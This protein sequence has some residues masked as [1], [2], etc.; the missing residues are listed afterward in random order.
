MEEV[1]CMSFMFSPYPYDD[2]NAVNRIA[3]ADSLAL[4]ISRDTEETVRILATRAAEAA[5][6]K[7][8]F[9]IGIEPYL[10][11]PA[12]LLS[13][14]LAQALHGMG[15]GVTIRQTDNLFLDSDLLDKKLQPHLPEDRDTDPVL[16][17]GSLFEGGY[18]ALLDEAAVQDLA[19]ELDAF[20]VSGRGIL[21][22]S[23]YAALVPA[24]VDRYDLRLYLDMTQ[25]TTI[26]NMR[27]GPW[28][29]VGRRERQALNLILRRCYYI[30]FEVM[31]ELRKALIDGGKIDY[32]LA[33]DRPDQIQ[34]MT[35]D[36]LKRLFAIMV[37]YPLRCK[38]V[39]LEGVWGGFYL[40]RLRQLPAEMKN[41]A[42]IFDLIP[43]EVSVVA[44]LGTMCVEFPFYSFIQT[45]GV[46]L[47]G[48]KCVDAFGGYF[49]IRFNY[50]DTFHSSGNMSIQV[51]PPEDYTAEHYNELGRQDESYYVV[52]TGQDAKTYVGFKND[53]DV[54]D[55][56]AKT[57]RAEQT[58]EGFD[59]DQ[60]VASHPSRPG[61]QFMLPAGT[62]H[63]SGR[64]QV[65]LEIGSLTVGSYTYKM[66]DYMRKDLEGKLRPI[67]TY[68]GDKVLRRDFR[69]DWVRENLIQEPRL[70]RSGDG[71]KEITVGEHDLLY[72]SLRNLVFD[73]RI[74]D[75]TCDRFHVLSLVDGEQVMVRSLNNPD[76][77][78]IQNYLDIVV[79]PASF[80]PYE[81][82]NTNPGVKTVVVHKTLLKDGFEN[83]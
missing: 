38:P 1:S 37:T 55:F 46:D 13:E 14:K 16:L 58:G 72:F 52:V 77:F 12:D 68:H 3:A 60:F 34:A 26:L 5:R 2:P 24:L 71:W 29:N 59:H 9:L 50:D 78:F 67:H 76:R 75:D 79:V 17:F 51:H 48:Q 42:W 20:S 65:V 32:Y 47:M 6:D 69:E 64:N 23:G 80:G 33:A 63:S 83:S 44:D 66:Y 74:E 18:E 30:D 53:A 19:Q 21:I 54:E 45:V 73:T 49:P 27:S 22:V 11:A 4:G 8:R 35:L 25:K 31:T 36:T 82:V 70:L 40:K 43:M 28:T 15:F 41:C 56:I 62:I 7:G 57:R 61:R 39:Y 10:S 81:I